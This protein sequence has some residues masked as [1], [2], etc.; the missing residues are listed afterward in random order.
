MELIMTFQIHALPP[1][2]F[3]RLFTLSDTQLADEGAH[4]VV[5]DEPGAFPCRVSLADAE[6]G[7][8]LILTNYFHLDERSPYR[9]SHAIY[10]R[11]DVKQAVPEPGD[12][13]AA[14]ANRLLSV[15]AFS[16]DH[17]MTNADVVDGNTLASSLRSI[18]ADP[19]V[20]YVHIHNAK[21][22]CFAAKATRT[23]RG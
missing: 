3:T 18:F 1:D 19:A 5:A 22:G 13:P 11:K 8:E 14:L 10:V 15:R 21:Q 9:A 2:S 4:R 12:V 6:V 23:A 16:C 7:D 20:D 17:M